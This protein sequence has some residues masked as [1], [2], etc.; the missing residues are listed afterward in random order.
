MI[1]NILLNAGYITKLDL[2]KKV[3]NTDKFV[4]IIKKTR[5]AYE[6]DMRND[7]RQR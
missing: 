2:Q 5:K 4:S 6:K 7:R 1:A 3:Q